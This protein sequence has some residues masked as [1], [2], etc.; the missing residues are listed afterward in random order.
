[1]EETKKR[2]RK[3]IKEEHFFD[4]SGKKDPK[5]KEQQIEEE[6]LT[7]DEIEKVATNV[8][9]NTAKATKKRKKKA[10]LIREITLFYTSKS[11]YLFHLT[12]V[13]IFWLIVIIF[14]QVSIINCEEGHHWMSHVAVGMFLILTFI[15]DWVFCS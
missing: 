7:V 11:F 3:S 2:K 6:G 14:P 9:Y 15:F 10:K 13:I 1:M 12:E 5:E 8:M 4:F